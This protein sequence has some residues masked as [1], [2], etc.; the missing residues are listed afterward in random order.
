MEQIKRQLVVQR[1]SI[2]AALKHVAQSR[3]GQSGYTDI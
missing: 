3:S 1:G 2:V